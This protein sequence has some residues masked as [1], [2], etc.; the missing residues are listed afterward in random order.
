MVHTYTFYTL[1]DNIRVISVAPK[2]NGV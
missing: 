1:R 2:K